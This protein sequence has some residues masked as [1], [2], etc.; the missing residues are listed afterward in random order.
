MKR[1]CRLVN[2][3]RSSYYHWSSELEQK[4]LSVEAEKELYLKINQIFIG[5]QKTYGAPRVWRQLLRNGISCSLRQVGKIMR[6][7][8][9]ISVHTK[10]KKKFIVTTDSSKNKAP[11]ENLL[12]RDFSAKVINEK[13]VGDVTFIWTPEGW[14]YL[15][16]ILDLFSRKVVGYALGRNNDAKLACAS[17]KMAIARRKQPRQLIYH[18]DRGSV[19]ASKDFKDLLMEN[20]ITPSMSRKGNCWDNAVAESFFNTLKVEEFYN[21]TRM[22]SS[23]GYCSPVEFE[24]IHAG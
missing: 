8:Q 18:S 13:W 19:Y 11:A 23:L 22:H 5:S 2:V 4:I 3:S 12:A 15:A 16:I 1:L 6:K 21:A 24:Q 7:N 20:E 9:L 17:F 14:L 10:R